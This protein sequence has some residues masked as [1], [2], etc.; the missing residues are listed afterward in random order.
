MNID[1]GDAKKEDLEFDH[2]TPITR[3]PNLFDM[4]VLMVPRKHALGLRHDFTTETN[5]NRV[6]EKGR[7]KN[8]CDLS[9]KRSFFL[10]NRHRASPS[11]IARAKNEATT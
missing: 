5:H 11:T 3:A 4:T 6:D 1:I 8:F 7:R 9:S 10:L 2:G